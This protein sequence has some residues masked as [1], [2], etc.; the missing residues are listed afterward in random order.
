MSRGGAWH[1]D[2]LALT[3]AGW[4]IVKRTARN[5][6]RAGSSADGDGSPMV[7]DSFPDVAAAGRVGYINA[8]RAQLARQ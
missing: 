2:E 5:F 3:S 6:W 1:D 4:R 8:L 7:A